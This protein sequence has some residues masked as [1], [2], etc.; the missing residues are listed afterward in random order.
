MSGQAGI[1][2]AGLK[3][4]ATHPCDHLTSQAAWPWRKFVL[5]CH[6]VATDLTDALSACV[7][8]NG[9]PKHVKLQVRGMVGWRN[10]WWNGGRYGL[11]DAHPAS[12][13]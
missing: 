12:P 11:G 9:Q 13:N 7:D 6:A 1:P 4:P 10:G 5:R 3:F 2:T 8:L